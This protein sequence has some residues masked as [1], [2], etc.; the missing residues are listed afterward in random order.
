MSSKVIVRGMKKEWFID[1]FKDMVVSFRGDP[2][3]VPAEGA[4]YIGFYLE[5]PVSAIT[6]IGIV[7]SFDRPKDSAIFHLKAI[8]ELDSPI[9]TKDGHAIR[10]QEYWTLEELGVQ[11]LSL[12]FNDFVV[13]GV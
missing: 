7:K 10:K 1:H 12:I 2:R 11:R 9:K 13:V 6:H 3:G 5:A 8:V 4:D